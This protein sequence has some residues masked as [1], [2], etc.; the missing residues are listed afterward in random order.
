MSTL[1]ESEEEHM[2]APAGWYSVFGFHGSFEGPYL[3]RWPMITGS[4]RHCARHQGKTWTTGFFEDLFFSG[5]KYQGCAGCALI[6][7]HLVCSERMKQTSISRQQACSSV[8][9]DSVYRSWMVLGPEGME[10]EKS[11]S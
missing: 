3:P 9:L 11:E 7:Y 5:L 2:M 1:S 4:V 10:A 6:W 8:K